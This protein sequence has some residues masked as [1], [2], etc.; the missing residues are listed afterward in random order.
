MIAAISEFCILVT[1]SYFTL[2]SPWIGALGSFVTG[3]G[4]TSAILF[5]AV[6]GEAAGALGIDPYWTAALNEMGAAVGKMISPQSF[7]IGMAAVNV[8]GKSPELMRRM[9][10][11]VA[12]FM[13]LISI[14][15]YA[16]AGLA[17]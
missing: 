4:T 15:A 5:G 7:S 16:G 17:F 13:V 3:S 9:L 1:G 8:Q 11:Y 12:V 14:F 6:Q 2:V 10:P